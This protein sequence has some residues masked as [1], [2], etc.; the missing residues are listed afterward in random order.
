MKNLIIALI[1][2]LYTLVASAGII[3]IS[4]FIDGKSELIIEDSTMYWHHSA[5]AAPGRWSNN[6][7]PTIVN[8]VSWQPT[9]PLAGRNDFCDCE[10]SSITGILPP[11]SGLTDISLN[12]ASGRGPVS[13]LEAPS[14][15]NGHRMEIEFDD[16]Y[17]GG[18]TWYNIEILYT[19]AP[20]SNSALLLALGLCG[21]LFRRNNPSGN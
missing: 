10:S 4:A 19:E 1:L 13:L 3:E 9:W 6:D 11:L 8:G 17:Y 7:H 12:I 15:L 5:F 16:Y 18:A 21:L 2:N 14:P 20:E